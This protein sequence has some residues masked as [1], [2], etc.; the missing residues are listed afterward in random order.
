MK[1]KA[2]PLTQIFRIALVTFIVGI[3]FTAVIIRSYNLDLSTFILFPSVVP[4][5]G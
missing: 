1:K 3:I 2:L 5:L 4:T